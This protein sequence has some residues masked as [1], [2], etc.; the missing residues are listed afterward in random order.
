MKTKI[1]FALV[2]SFFLFSGTAF[3][4]HS[5]GVAHCDACH[6]MHNSAD[7][8]R[9]GS[10][11]NAPKLMKGSDA[12]STCLNCHAGDSVTIPEGETSPTGGTGY[13]NSLTNIGNGV[14]QGG[15]FFWVSPA[16][17]YDYPEWHGG[18]AIMS[19]PDNHGHNVIA[20]DFGL[21]VDGT[22]VTAPGGIMPSNTLSCTSCHDPHGRVD[23]GTKAGTAPISGSGSYA[24][25]DDNPLP[26]GGS[27]LGNFRLLGDAGYKLIT[28]NAPVA[29]SVNAGY[30]QP[31]G[32]GNATDYG[33]GMSGWCLSCHTLYN[34]GN[35]HSIGGTV[36]APYNSYVA[37]GD[38]NGEAATSYDQMV[39]FQ[40]GVGATLNPKSTVG[41]DGNSQLGCITCHRAHASAF[42]NATRWDTTH[43]FLAD[44]GILHEVN[45]TLMTGGAIPY[46]RDG[47]A[48]DPVAEYGQYQRSLCNKC[49]VKD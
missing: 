37:T 2:A 12:S 28:S 34:A 39:P 47:A 21:A 22:N 19:E 9:T 36:P 38:Y 32:Y 18:P 45:T 20:S 7:N 11:V 6:S 14:S 3:A 29:M 25:T 35:M 43:E 26:T 16:G 8:L 27:I 24:I 33:T 4:L 31:G 44:S 40:R 13:H 46:Y 41:S 15:D 42:E 5:G 30:G 23:G 49:H 17:A 1:M 10:D 48:F